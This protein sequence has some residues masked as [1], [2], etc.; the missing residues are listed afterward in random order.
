[1]PPQIKRLLLLFAIFIGLFLLVRHFLVPESFGKF[2]HYRGLSLDENAAMELHYAGKESCAECHREI[3]DKLS[4]DLHDVLSCETCHGPGRA[5]ADSPDSVKVFLPKER[6]F[7]GLCHDLMPGRRTD[8][9]HQVVLSEHNTGKYC[10]ECHNPHAP[11]ELK[12]Q[13]PP[14]GTF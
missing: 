7:C 6:E 3:A 10:I 8:A 11:W 13:T 12:V 2:G 14:G 9:V 5:H 1:M 4:S